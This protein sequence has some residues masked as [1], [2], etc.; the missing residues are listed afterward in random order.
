MTGT[1]LKQDCPASILPSPGQ[2]NNIAQAK[3]DTW[4]SFPSHFFLFLPFN[5]FK[6]R[7]LFFSFV[8]GIAPNCAGCVFV[9]TNSVILILLCA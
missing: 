5:F 9:L 6:C 2:E 1:I 8:K 7:F 3:T 4:F